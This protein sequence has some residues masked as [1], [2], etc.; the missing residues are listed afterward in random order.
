MRGHYGV[1]ARKQGRIARLRLLLEGVDRG[2]GDGDRLQRGGERL[3]VDEHL[4][5][6]VGKDAFRPEPRRQRR[7]SVGT[8]AP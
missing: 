4:A 7:V 5:H 6:S 1:G 2:A 8:F 3:V